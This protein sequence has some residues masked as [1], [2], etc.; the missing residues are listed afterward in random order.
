MIRRKRCSPCSARVGSAARGFTLLEVIVVMSLLSLVM[1][2]IGSALRTTAQTETR[3]DERLQRTDEMRVA[4]EFLRTVLGRVSAQKTTAPVAVGESPFIFSGA[5][6]ELSWL[7]IMPARYGAGGRHHFRLSVETL[8]TERALVLR[9]LPWESGVL[10]DWSRAELHVLVHGA[11][12]LSAQ[13]EN[14]VA[15]PT[16]WAPQW[17][18]TIGLPQRVLLSLQ[19]AAGPWPDLVIAMR[20]L[21]ASESGGPGQ[22]VFGGGL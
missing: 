5:P 13:Y 1:L 19:T 21:I 10:P 3:I 9:Y 20:P 15:E 12:G 16:I 14:A 22:A 8:P 17:S 2:A 7:G 18:S 11:V 4:S 6:Q